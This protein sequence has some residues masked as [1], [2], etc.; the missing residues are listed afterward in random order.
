MSNCAKP[1]GWQAGWQPGPSGSAAAAGRRRRVEL[2]PV[3][4]RR[5]EPR[6]VC[7]RLC[8]PGPRLRSCALARLLGAAAALP[9][10]LP[11]AARPVSLLATSLEDTSCRPSVRRVRPRRVCCQ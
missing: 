11:A 5:T 10:C 8:A 1:G 6:R 7:A 3:E 9:E 4:T 2:S